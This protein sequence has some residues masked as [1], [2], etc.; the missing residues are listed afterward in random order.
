MKDLPFT[1]D[2]LIAGAGPVGLFLACELR[3]AG[4]SVLVLEQAEDPGSPLKELP[5]GMRGLSVPTLEALYRRGILSE[6]SLSNVSG[7]HSPKTSS[8]PHCDNDARR[9]GGHFAGIQFFHDKIDVS[10]WQYHLPGPVATNTPTTMATLESVLA[11]RAAAIGVEIRRGTR[12][13]E[14]QQSSTE[15]TVHAGGED[16]QGRWLVGCDGGRSVVRKSGGFEFVGTDPEFTGYSV[17]VEIEDPDALATGR[18]YTATGMFMYQ[19]PGN[20]SMVDFD[21]GAFHR[22]RPITI[23]HVQKV[24]RHIS[25]VQ[26]TVLALHQATTWTDR[27]FQATTYRKGRVLLAGDAAHIH[28]P[29]GGQGL[30]LGLGDA[31]NLGWKLA[32]TIRG[33]AP[34]GLLDSY[35]TERHAIGAQV[36]DW[37]RAQVAIMRPSR[38]SRALEAIF[39]DL[40]DTTDGAT[41]FAER[42]WGTRL[43]YDFGCGDHPLVGCS[44]PD[45][46][47]ADGTRLGEYL[48]GGKGVLLDFDGHSPLLEYRNLFDEQFVCI[49][50]DVKERLGV[51]AVLVRPDG[52]VAWVAAEDDESFVEAASRWFRMAR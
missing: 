24:L 18:H 23:D 51:S 33:Q 12:V 46:E 4:V 38:S 39:R 14:F 48:R 9:P 6:V 20:I 5:F 32:S 43:R 28:S 17:Q 41:Y 36:L 11:T 21:G 10:Q 2:V 52:Y 1:Y 34:D 37:S 25:G 13:Q 35:T 3:L 27:A 47:L 49:A 19:K 30:N 22:T 45:F 44:A 15:V 31:M 50:S 7:I 40:V 16:L 42:V 8:A 26:V 29:L